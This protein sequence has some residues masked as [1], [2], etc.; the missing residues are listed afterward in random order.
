MWIFLALLS[1]FCYAT[2][3]IID[4]I[5]V[6]QYG[7]ST[8]EEG[9]E[10][11]LMTGFA[12]VLSVIALI[13]FVPLVFLGLPTLLPLCA[14][15]FFVIAMLPYTYALHRHNVVY[16]MMILLTSMP[17]MSYFF[18]L[19]LFDEHFSFL[20]IALGLLALGSGILFVK[21]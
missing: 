4:K 8:D 15:F 17:I 12:N 3:N 7:K 18:G 6:R 16:P 9:M 11:L 20:K 2:T 21:V 1:S 5:L 13:F 10:L 19:F 14:G